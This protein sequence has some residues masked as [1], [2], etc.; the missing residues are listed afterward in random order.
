MQPK[1]EAAMR[2]RAAERVKIEKQIIKDFGGCHE[3]RLIESFE[4]SPHL[5]HSSSAIRVSSIR[6]DPE[7]LE[8]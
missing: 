1:S 7:H 4:M 6:V 5:I 2:L 3:N 8:K